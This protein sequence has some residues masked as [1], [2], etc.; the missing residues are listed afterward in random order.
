MNLTYQKAVQS[1][2]RCRA[3]GFF[4]DDVNVRLRNVD[5]HNLPMAI[6]IDNSTEVRVAADVEVARVRASLAS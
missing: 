6:E 5:V 2:G 1:N 3:S 4:R